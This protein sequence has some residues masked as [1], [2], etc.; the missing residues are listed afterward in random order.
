LQN[1][2]YTVN[3]TEEV[4]VTEARNITREMNVTVSQ[5]VT[6]MRNVTVLEAYNVTKLITEERIIPI[7]PPA[8]CKN[9]TISCFGKQG[10]EACNFPHGTCVGQN[11][12]LCFGYHGMECQSQNSIFTAG[13]NTH[14]Q[15][16]LSSN[17]QVNSLTKIDHSAALV[18]ITFT[19]IIG[20]EAGTFAISGNGKLYGWGTNENYEL[21]DNTNIQR[22]LPIQVLMS[23]VLGTRTVKMV[24]T[25]A[26]TSHTLVLSNDG[27]VF[28]WGKKSLWSTWRWINKY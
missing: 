7:L 19:S 25:S 28:A 22:S 26:V 27:L 13:S 9:V 18:N 5:N 20:Q 21:N 15:L 17:N 23:G 4:N 24:A 8:E 14:G 6:V 12:C 11:Q 2:T 16:G 3:V 1:V 10:T